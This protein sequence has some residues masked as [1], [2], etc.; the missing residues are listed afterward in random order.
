M[1]EASIEMEP[2]RSVAPRAVQT[3]SLNALE[4]RI[5]RRRLSHFR[6]QSDSE[7]DHEPVG[8]H[9]AET[10]QLLVFP[11]LDDL[12]PLVSDQEQNLP[13]PTQSLLLSPS[14]TSAQHHCYL[15]RH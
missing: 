10:Q 14:G 15:T 13:E 4:Q 9:A 12:G 8:P 2:N 6:Y 3:R 11:E 5:P 1:P 7:S